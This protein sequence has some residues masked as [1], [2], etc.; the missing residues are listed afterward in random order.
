M[1]SSV[2]VCNRRTFKSHGRSPNSSCLTIM[3]A[4]RKHEFWQILVHFLPGWLTTDDLLRILLQLGPRPMIPLP[5]LVGLEEHAVRCDP[6][7]TACSIELTATLPIAFFVDQVEALLFAGRA[8]LH[9]VDRPR[10]WP[11]NCKSVHPLLRRHGF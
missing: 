9:A 1:A 6:L 5:I 10:T 11:N 7:I 4:N 8:V 2:R 3:A